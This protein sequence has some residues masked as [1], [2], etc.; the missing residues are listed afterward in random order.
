MQPKSE[1]IVSPEEYAEAVAEER[2]ESSRARNLTEIG[3]VFGLIL[4]AVWT[5]QGRLNSFFSTSAAACVLGFAIAG[6]WNARDM[7]L[8]AP[9][10]GVS[11]ILLIGAGLC[12]AIWLTGQGLRF[13]GA[14]NPLPWS[15]S[16]EYAIW[17]LVQEF[18]VQSVFFVRLESMFG[19]R[20]AVY[21]SAGLYAA[22]HIPSPVLAPLSFIGGI[23]F[24]ELF[25]RY[26]NLFPIGVIHAALG[27][28]I[29]A[30][31]PD[32]WLHHMRVGIGY[33]ALH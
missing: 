32:Q 13:A 18:I 6:P 8:A 14:G 31:L 19:S 20:R 23:V 16:W 12:G 5:P 27:L 3:I 29:A 25:R 17:A 33:L 10:R 1:F 11:K 2:N 30:S 26:R 21:Y 4:A 28:T 7:G 15:R 9:H 24:C 22:A